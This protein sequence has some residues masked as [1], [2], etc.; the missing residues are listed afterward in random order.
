MGWP[1]RSRPPSSSSSSTVSIL[2][3]GG[4]ALA[5]GADPGLRNPHADQLALAACVRTGIPARLP[6]TGA[7]LDGEVPAEV[8]EKLLAQLDVKSE[9]VLANAA[10]TV[11]RHVF[12]WHPSEASDFLLPQ[13]PDG[14]RGRVTVRDAGNDVAMTGAAT[15]VSAGRRQPSRRHRPGSTP[16]QTESLGEAEQSSAASRESRE[17]NT[18]PRRRP[19]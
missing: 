11:V 10:T 8:V 7:G 4:D 12:D 14:R 19:G 13:R 3:V 17:S 1:T 15:G 18:R 9:P 6:V 16:D 5:N 2:D